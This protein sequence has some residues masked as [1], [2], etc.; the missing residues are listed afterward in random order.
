MTI[1]NILDFKKQLNKLKPK[2][3]DRHCSICGR[4]ITPTKSYLESR[5]CTR[6]R[7]DV[8]EGNRILHNVYCKGD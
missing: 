8:M 1:R 2:E 6:H 4:F 7:Q 3:K 5:L